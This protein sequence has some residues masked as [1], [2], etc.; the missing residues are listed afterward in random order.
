MSETEGPF[1]RIR[2]SLMIFL[3]RR[4]CNDGVGQGWEMNA[5][6]TSKN[7]S[8]DI[9]DAD[10]RVTR[11]LWCPRRA[12]KKGKSAF[13]PQATRSRLGHRPNATGH[14]ASPHIL[15]SLPRKRLPRGYKP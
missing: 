8:S 15:C 14:E 2:L 6:L 13:F 11:C 7:V 9:R 12:G 5:L 4:R 10:T 1:D 3:I